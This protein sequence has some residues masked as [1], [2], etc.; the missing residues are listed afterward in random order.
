MW[1]NT[2]HQRRSVPSEYRFHIACVEGAK[3]ED[4]KDVGFLDG[5]D[6]HPKDS[7]QL[8]EKKVIQLTSP[9]AKNVREK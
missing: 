7:M 3:I 9:L 1:Y 5:R 2:D 8:H 6:N 4:Y